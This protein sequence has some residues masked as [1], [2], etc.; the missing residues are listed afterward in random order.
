[1]KKAQSWLIILRRHV[2]IAFW[3]NLGQ[4]RTPWKPKIYEIPIGIV[5]PGAFCT[6]LTWRL[7]LLRFGTRNPPFWRPRTTRFSKNRPPWAMRKRSNFHADFLSLPKASWGTSCT[8]HGPVRRRK[9]DPGGAPGPP[10]SVP[11]AT[12][13]AVWSQKAA[14]NHPDP[15]ETSIL[16]HFGDD[17]GSFLLISDPKGIPRTFQMTSRK[18]RNNFMRVPILHPFPTLSEVNIP[19]AKP[20]NS[21]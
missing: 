13:E 21:T 11:G 12:P 1:M 20:V 2:V 3:W 9:S 8:Q 10:R 14:R 19:T 4:K 6:F 5:E 7:I 16:D 15:L 17:F 18:T